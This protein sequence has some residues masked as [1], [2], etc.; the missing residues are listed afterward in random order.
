MRGLLTQVE[1]VMHW[2]GMGVRVGGV[3]VMWEVVG[4]VSQGWMVVPLPSPLSSSRGR[5]LRSLRRS[6]LLVW[7]G[8]V[9]MRDDDVG[10]L[11][12]R[13]GAETVVVHGLG[14]SLQVALH[15]LWV[16]GEV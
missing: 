14:V 8:P 13:P 11:Q 1:G 2:M 10:V 4:G 5:S 3:R 9:G 7:G 12:E 15:V 16:K 6:P